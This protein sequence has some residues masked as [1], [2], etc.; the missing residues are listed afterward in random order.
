[1]HLRKWWRVVVRGSEVRRIPSP[2]PSQPRNPAMEPVGEPRLFPPR[3]YKL[4]KPVPP[5]PLL[6]RD[7]C[8]F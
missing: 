3:Y 5:P 4:P 1:M 8:R 7:R 6:P 2:P